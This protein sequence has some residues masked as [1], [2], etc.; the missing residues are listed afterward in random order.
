MIS[1]R[2]NFV[3]LGVVLALLAGGVTARA[4]S[5][6]PFLQ[7][8][9][10]QPVE[11]KVALPEVRADQKATTLNLAQK[12]AGTNLVLFFF[13]EQCGV[14]FRYKQRLQSLQKEFT[15]KGFTF[16]GVRCGRREKPDEPLD[17]AETRYLKM[18]FV[19][20]ATGVL[21]ERFRVR[22]SLT[23]AVMDKAGKMRYR[24][25]FDNNVDE[26]RVTKPYLRNALRALAAGK[27]VTVKE[28]FA[29]GCAILPVK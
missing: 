11:L 10:D 14:T 19:D 25:G 13:S 23:F 15:G 3:Q 28:G 12:Q 26:K 4:Q 21:A 9:I 22:Q 5:T 27:P 16:V 2:I 7:A 1:M 8:R 24:G 17:L 20:D 6:N 29:L 18:V